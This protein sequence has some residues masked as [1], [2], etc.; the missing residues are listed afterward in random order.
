MTLDSPDIVIMDKKV[1]QNLFEIFNKI[2]QLFKTSFSPDLILG[3][4]KHYRSHVFFLSNVF[5]IGKTELIFLHDFKA[6]RKAVLDFTPNIKNN[7]SITPGK[8]ELWSSLDL[9][10][11]LVELSDG[12]FFIKIK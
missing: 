11:R 3:R 10:E 1:F 6:R 7:S 8:L 2:K 5:S 12:Q 9:V 4:W